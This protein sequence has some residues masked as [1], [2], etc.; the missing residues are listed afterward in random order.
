MIGR[1][2]FA[3]AGPGAAR[4]ALASLALAAACAAPAQAAIFGDDEARK[5]IIDLRGRFDQLAEQNRARQAEQAAQFNDQMNAMKRSILDLNSQLELQRSENAK[6]RG[7]VEQL[8]RDI[9][10]VQRK[11]ADM[12]QGFEDRIRKIEPQKVTLDEKE[13]LADPDEKRTYDEA[14]AA[15]R[16]SE[17]DRA[18][19]G[20]STLLKRWPASGYRESALFW[21]GN[22]Q[23]GQRNY[24]G[25]IGSFRQLV[26]TSPDSPRA[27]EALLAIAN[28]QAELK[29]TKSARRTIEEL[30]R[31]YPKSEAA[32]AGRERLVSLK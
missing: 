24:Q 19:S 22:A 21:L 13:F 31:T 25:A 29:D 2:R 10:E 16:R 12:V 26:S 7:Q 11:Q 4:A 17:F 23:Y 1:L 6:L 30:L 8:A 14:L 9:A 5:A 3:S 20:L 32:A 15:V 27:P 18:A 28:C